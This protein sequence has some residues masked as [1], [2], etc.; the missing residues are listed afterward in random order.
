MRRPDFYT[1]APMALIVLL[2]TLHRR[3]SF[4]LAGSPGD[5]ARSGAAVWR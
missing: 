2:G 3:P 1:A 5:P 4:R